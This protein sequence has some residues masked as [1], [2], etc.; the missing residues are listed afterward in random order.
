MKNLLSINDFDFIVTP[1]P[2]TNKNDVIH[3]ENTISYN[4]T[5]H[6]IR[7]NPISS[8]VLRIQ[9]SLQEDSYIDWKY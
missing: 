4:C 3:E 2:N 7:I 9:S 5:E 6:I 1:P 8:L